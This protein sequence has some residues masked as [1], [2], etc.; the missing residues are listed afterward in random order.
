[1]PPN[2]IF[3]MGCLCF[4][5]P[6]HTE[7]GWGIL[8]LLRDAALWVCTLPGRAMS[9]DG[10]RVEDANAH[11]LQGGRQVSKER[12]HQP[13]ELVSHSGPRPR[14]RWQLQATSMGLNAPG[15]I[16]RGQS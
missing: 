9:S 16:T 10:S 3:S 8:S 7:H 4:S 12:L 11:P 6:G 5:L 15:A 2:L 13:K 14:G 1:M